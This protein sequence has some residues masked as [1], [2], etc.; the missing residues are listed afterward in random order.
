MPV[1]KTALL[2]SLYRQKKLMTSMTTASTLPPAC[3]QAVPRPRIF[4][5]P[6]TSVRP[7]TAASAAI[8]SPAPSSHNVGSNQLR[9][10]V[11]QNTKSQTKVATK[12]Q[13]ERDQHRM[14]GMTGDAGRAARIRVMPRRE[15]V[16]RVR[17]DHIRNP[18]LSARYAPLGDL[19]DRSVTS[20][21]SFYPAQHGVLPGVRRCRTCAET[22]A[23]IAV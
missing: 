21:D 4:R 17:L 22:R 19:G 2:P 16:P 8:I 15:P 14:D 5:L 9:L 13:W 23:P 18:K 1:G 12:T 3:H 20:S 7:A 6:S 10:R 11:P